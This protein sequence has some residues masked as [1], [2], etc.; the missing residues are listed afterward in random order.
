[1]KKLLITSMAAVAV[2][3]CA[4]AEFTD[5]SEN[6]ESKNIG[7][8]FSQSGEGQYINFGSEWSTAA[9]PDDSV[10]TVTNIAD[11]GYTLA[12]G[13]TK[14]LAIDTST[15][16]MRNAVTSEDASQTG[17]VMAGDESIFFDSLV[18]F[19]ATE[20]IPTPSTG[21]K[22]VIGLF[23]DEDPEVNADLGALGLDNAT[24][25]VVISAI[26]ENGA[27]VGIATNVIDNID[28]NT[29]KLLVAPEEWHR[30]TIQ[31]M[32]D[33]GYS[34]EIETPGFRVF[35]DGSE[36]K[37]GGVEKVFYSLVEV[38]NNEGEGENVIKGVAFDGKGAVDNLVF[39]TMDPFA[40][41]GYKIRVS[42]TENVG[43]A[44]QSASYKVDS[45][46]TYTGFNS[47]DD[48][49]VLLTN[50]AITFK[51]WIGD[52]AKLENGEKCE[53]E[54]NDGYYA[55]TRTVVISDFKKDGTDTIEF[56]IVEE[57]ESGDDTGDVTVG[58]TPV[59]IGDDGKITNIT[60]AFDGQTVSGNLDTSKF[61]AYYV[62][63]VDNGVLSIK[64]DQ[65]VAAP[66]A[67]ATDL[68]EGQE[69]FDLDET[70]DDESPAVGIRIKTY[71]G[72]WYGLGTATTLG[73]MWSEPEADDWVEGDGG[74]KQL[75]AKKPVEGNAAFFMI[76]V[77]DTNP[78]Q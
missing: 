66:F 25:L 49:D 50:S 64:L 36:V 32:N 21:D 65:K 71:S 51:F 3:I 7:P 72:L 35:V 11:I 41:E 20:S 60:T 9:T 6:F 55:W 67:E 10:F 12:D 53:D 31:V 52:G 43:D 56:S 78:K 5:S 46:E 34:P 27:K 40:A 63:S 45:A 58:G 16:L 33:S 24:N 30:L 4:K 54:E 74:N 62:V 15:P 75:K 8:L 44:V 29:A 37:V 77:R 38:V 57:S 73:G 14:A 61:K 19:T 42:W 68:T 70:M 22:L 17:Y 23:A 26:L 76:K 28:I 48:L 13:N 2:S 69:V 1:M 47:G 39:T 18:Q 59:E